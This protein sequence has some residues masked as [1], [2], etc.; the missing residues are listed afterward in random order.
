MRTRRYLAR[1]AAE[2]AGAAGRAGDPAL[3][4]PP[5]ASSGADAWLSRPRVGRGPHEFRLNEICARWGAPRSKVLRAVHADFVP[6]S[7]REVDGRDIWILELDD[8]DLDLADRL[9]LLEEDLPPL[10]DVASFRWFD[11]CRML[12]G[13]AG[14]PVPQGWCRAY[15]ALPDRYEGDTTLC[16]IRGVV[17]VTEEEG[18][19]LVR[20]LELM[21]VGVVSAKP[22]RPI[23]GDPNA[24]LLACLSP[25]VPILRYTCLDP[26]VGK[27]VNGIDGVTAARLQQIGDVRDRDVAIA[28]VAKSA[29]DQS[30]MKLSTRALCFLRY[31]EAIGGIDQRDEGGLER[32][33]DEFIEGRRLPG[34]PPMAVIAAIDTVRACRRDFEQWA[35]E[36]IPEDLRAWLLG[37]RPRLPTSRGFWQRFGERIRMHADAGS[38][39]RKGRTDAVA[40]DF[41]GHLAEAEANLAEALLVMEEVEKGH[42]R[43]GDAA[44]FAFSF[45]APILDDRRNDT[46]AV[47][48]V[49]MRSVLV[50]HHLLALSRASDPSGERLRPQHFVLSHAPG[51]AK[52]HLVPEG[53]RVAIYVGV[54]AVDPAGPP[55][56]PPLIIAPCAAGAMLPP[57][58]LATGTVEA[59]RAFFASSGVPTLGSR[60]T[61]LFG[62][63]PL[64]RKLMLWSLRL[65]G[66]IVVPAAS[67]AQGVSNGHLAYLTAS[68]SMARGGTIIQMIDDRQRGWGHGNVR[69]E[70]RPC[71][72]ARPKLKKERMRIPVGLGVPMAMRRHVRLTRRL[73][74]HGATLRPARPSADHPEGCGEDKYPLQARGVALNTGQVSYCMSMLFMRTLL[75][76]DP[77]HGAAEV[78]FDEGD[79]MED[80]SQDMTQDSPGSAKAYVRRKKAEEERR[81]GLDHIARRDAHDVL[82]AVGRA[83]ARRGRR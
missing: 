48:L 66:E 7:M 50:E 70:R 45:P 4:A 47:M 5:P 68:T 33:L 65:T 12:V 9:A 81:R 8:P 63:T 69:G 1:L 14:R 76:H 18:V 61:G 15:L 55:A 6:A 28:H 19:R 30:F 57:S 75:S 10:P 49:M 53:E 79:D 60:P 38:E 23:E 71:M 2:D 40:D 41:D 46:G 72:I 11:E 43:A 77:R 22:V 67:F 24:E 17:T 29:A 74:G 52:S 37:N 58:F 34:T 26:L 27:S 25:S 51:G 3:T 16:E 80:I 83:A 39:V 32:A 21:D 35:L 64:E 44:D 59:R 73:E 13:G 62:G 78:R 56:S 20:E 82:G 31:F 54:E 36:P 42:A